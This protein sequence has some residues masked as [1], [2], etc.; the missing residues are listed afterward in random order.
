MSKLTI[1]WLRI[2][3]GLSIYI[4]IYRWFIF[5]NPNRKIGWWWLGIS[6]SG[7]GNPHSEA[8]LFFIR[9]LKPMHWRKHHEMFWDVL[10]DRTYDSS[11]A[12][13]CSDTQIDSE[14]DFLLWN[15]CMH[16]KAMRW[17]VDFRCRSLVFLK[18]AW[19]SM[20]LW[21]GNMS[22]GYWK[23]NLWKPSQSSHQRLAPN[24]QQTLTKYN[25]RS[26][27]WNHVQPHSQT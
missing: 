17:M 3:M 6:H 2:A 11:V 20:I 14:N 4:Y 27:K 12:T 1:W 16:R 19:T 23:K 15:A 13:S 25:N 24:F 8:L 7:Y 10:R 5:E 18:L 21:L 22:S 9:S 26:F